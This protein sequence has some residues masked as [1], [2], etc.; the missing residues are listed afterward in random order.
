VQKIEFFNI[1]VVILL[2][3]LSL[4]LNTIKLALETELNLNIQAIEVL[5]RKISDYTQF[6]SELKGL[7]EKISK[8]HDL[9]IIILQ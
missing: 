6:S 8:I 4:L 1:N 9:V 7:V 2:L 3:V 5:K